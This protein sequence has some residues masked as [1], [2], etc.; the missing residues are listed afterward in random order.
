MRRR[1]PHITLDS[2]LASRPPNFFREIF[3]SEELSMLP[4]LIDSAAA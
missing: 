4:R 1:G 2:V 3:L